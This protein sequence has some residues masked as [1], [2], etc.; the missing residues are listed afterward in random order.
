MSYPYDKTY[1][2]KIQ[3]RPEECDDIRKAYYVLRQKYAHD[4]NLGNS[5]DMTIKESFEVL[6]EA[7]ELASI[8]VDGI[9]DEYHF[10]WD[11][12]DALLPEKK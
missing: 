8:T 10:M 9:T 7:F 6:G 11:V 2:E 3:E 4:H 12:I 5:I 1:L